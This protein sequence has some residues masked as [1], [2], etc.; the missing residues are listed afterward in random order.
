MN[1]SICIIT[2]NEQE[3]IERC[4]KS[5]MPYEME[6]IVA[7]TGSIDNTKDIVQRYTDKVFDFEWCD[8][9]AA[10][11]NFAISK[12]SNDYIIMLDS[13]EYIDK[14]EESELIRTI[15]NNS[16]KVGRIQ[17]KNVFK[18]TDPCK[19]SREWV[20]RIFNKKSYHYEGRIHE[21]IVRY[22]GKE[23]DTFQAPVTI[24]HTGYDLTE[25]EKSA[26]AKRNISL[27]EK[28][29]DRL[30]K[31]FC[32]NNGLNICEID[33]I[34]LVNHI[35]END[36]ALSLILQK[37]EYLPYILYQLGKGYY[38]AMDYPKACDCFSCALS[39]DLNPKLEYVTDAV[40]TYGYALVNADRADEALM[41]ENIYNEFGNTA[42]FQFLMGI[43]YMNNER[44]D[45]AVSEFLKAT[46]HKECRNVGSNSYLAYYNI[47][48][49]YE[50]L[51]DVDK[52]IS[53]YRRCGNY[54]QAK[55]R[56]AVL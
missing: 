54:K 35:F 11:K 16:D 13:D 38:M 27:L 46:K 37:D 20:S 14:F 32:K 50:C 8:D 26:K 53:Y 2:K 3:N 9:F 44:F 30:I 17:I 25:K 33:G 5:L 42:D 47:G 43:I 4:L 39:F 21:Q 12:T 15:G 1:L 48:V 41:F 45:D 56:L 29:L 31:L 19:E 36:S 23:Y 10:A 40:E 34:E 52:A 49:I 18:K 7:D 24:I 22:D 28:E 55:D 51:G 6:I